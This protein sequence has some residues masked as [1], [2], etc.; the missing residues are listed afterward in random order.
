MFA[1]R[2]WREIFLLASAVALLAA[3]AMSGIG[4]SQGKANR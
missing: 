3:V 1:H 4:V 2:G